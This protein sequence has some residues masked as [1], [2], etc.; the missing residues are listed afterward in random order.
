M[1]F[2]FSNNIRI[3]EPWGLGGLGPL[4]LLGASAVSAESVGHHSSACLPNFEL[5]VHDPGTKQK[6]RFAPQIGRLEW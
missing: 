1:M 4:A 5:L 3:P 2:I 6:R